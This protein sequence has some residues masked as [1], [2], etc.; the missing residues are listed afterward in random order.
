VP[1]WFWLIWV[2]LVA[3][4][5][6]VGFRVVTRKSDRTIDPSANSTGRCTVPVMM[7]GATDRDR[8]ME[9]QECQVH[10]CPCS[11]ARRSPSR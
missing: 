8:P 11:N 6:I 1:F 7:T 3:L 10:R 9:T 5:V 4:A 2:L